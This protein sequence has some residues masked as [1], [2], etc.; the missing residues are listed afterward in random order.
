M[1]TH[2]ASFLAAWLDDGNE[3]CDMTD[4]DTTNL[5]TISELE[6]T[7]DLDGTVE[8]LGDGGC[9]CGGCDPDRDRREGGDG[10]ETRILRTGDT[11]YG[12]VVL[13]KIRHQQ[14]AKTLRERCDSTVTLLI[15]PDRHNTYG[16]KALLAYS[17]QYFETLLYGCL[18][19]SSRLCVELPEDDRRVVAAFVHWTSSGVID[20]ASKEIL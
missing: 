13:Q 12:E 18:R 3:D 7:E 9:L 19:E 1:E 16:E 14:Q 5:S 11:T 20:A 4:T 17:S 15:S 10:G 8:G 2:S 6:V